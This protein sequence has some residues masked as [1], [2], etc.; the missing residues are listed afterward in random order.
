MVEIKGYENRYA[1][2]EDGNIYSYLSKKILKTADNGQGYLIVCLIDENGRSK[3]HRV[4]QLI[5]NAFIPKPD[6][7]EEGMKID[8]GHK[9]SNRKNN[10]IENLCWLTRAQNLDDEHF[11]NATKTKQRTKIKCVE[12]GIIYQS[13]AQA[14][15]DVGCSRYNINLCL[16]GKQKTAAGYHWVRVYD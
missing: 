2:M 8:V 9:D 3:T 4:H 16:L 10:K 6:W 13:M 12:T 11:R 1:A 5:A 15:N 14:A 7:W